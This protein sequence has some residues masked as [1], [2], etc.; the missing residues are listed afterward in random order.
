[1]QVNVGMSLCAAP[2]TVSL[3]MCLII[4]SYLNIEYVQLKLFLKKD[5]HRKNQAVGVLSQ[6]GGECEETRKVFTLSSWT[7]ANDLRVPEC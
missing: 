1:M 6:A 4:V 5:K 3:N 2:V 7:L